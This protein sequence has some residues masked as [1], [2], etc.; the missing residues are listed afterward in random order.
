M[1]RILVT[2]ALPYANGPLHLGHLVEYTQTDIWVRHQKLA[3]NEC[4]YVC[5]D[6]T[7]GTPIM[8]RAQSEGITPEEL[9]ARVGAEH[10]ADFAAF[11]IDFDHF[12]STNAPENR[13]RTEQ[14]FQSLD[15]AGH[16][17]RRTIRQAYDAKAGMFL[18]DR[19]VKGTC[20]RCKAA[21]QYGDS[22]EKCGAT[23]SPSEL[24]D[25][26]SAVSGTT[27]EERDSE[28]LFFQLGHFEALLK[29]WVRSGTVDSGVAN[30]LDEWFTAGLRDWD[31]SRD[32]PY[33]GFGIPGAPGKFFY[34]W[35]D[36]P[37][38]YI[39]S[40]DAL[41]AKRGVDVAA[42]HDEFWGAEG[43]RKAGTELY[44]FIGK[45]I[46]YFHAL[47]WPAVLNGAGM[48]TPNGVFVHGFLTVN[49]QKMSKSRGTFI[50]ARQYLD[51][52][53]AEPLRFYFASKLT[54]GL[55]DM[56]L[57][58]ED[59]TSRFNSEVVGKV[60]NI[61]SRCAGFLTRSFEGR[62]A[63][64]LP[65][66]ALFAEFAAARPRIQALYEAR[67]YAAAV[68]EV[69]ML[70]DKANQ[71][72]DTQKPW[73][74]AK[75]PARAQEVQAVCTQGLNLFRSLVGFLKP[76]M[77]NLAAGAEA[78]LQAPLSRW[79]QLDTPLLDHAIRTYEA[80]ATRLDSKVVAQLVVTPPTVSEPAA[81]AKAAQGTVESR[82]Q[83]R[84][85]KAGAANNDSGASKQAKAAA[86]A[87]TASA[88]AGAT[89]EIDLEALMKVELRVAE[90]LE[91]STVEGSD[92]LLKLRVSL[93]THAEG[94]VIERTIFSG[95]RSAYAPEQLVGRQVV[96]VANLKPRKMRFGTSEGMVLAAENG[97]G[98]IFV[99]SPDAGAVT[100]SLIK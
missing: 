56:D 65:E 20:P 21:D 85:H 2:S 58:L 98:G 31:I 82:E 32:A 90:V 91:A 3:G 35:L 13:A 55:D 59:F 36:A 28:H 83:A 1:R 9:I 94:T 69:M 7:H 78:F 54:P 24:I 42:T 63:A 53:P 12:H 61:G 33:F 37:I 68:R 66:P 48:R 96:I 16:I 27:P 75:D 72:I 81:E 57:S 95:I 88:A 40:F 17:A 23:Y 18:P 30:K 80:L 74:L 50:T 29:E 64:S 97:A 6:D 8:L 38:G 73:L 11:G 92:K 25:P 14:I 15:A 41:S 10:A 49:G 51:L 52:L 89:P 26:V 62:L 87:A 79:E 44:H 99:L 71:Y 45:D 4:Y 5:A 93:G 77:P 70:A 34:V 84:S 46:L 39:G 19:Y 76:V 43:A 100:G 22:C 86:P 67:D 47:F 60:V